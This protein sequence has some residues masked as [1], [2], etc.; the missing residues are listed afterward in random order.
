MK[1]PK[2]PST[3]IPE[4]VQGFG[5]PRSLAA[6]R[7]EAGVSAAGADI[8]PRPISINIPPPE[9]EP[10]PTARDFFN[11][12]KTVTIAAGPGTVIE[13]ASLT[14]QFGPGVVAVIKYVS[15]F[16]DAP[17]LATNVNWALLINGAPVP[18]WEALSFS[19]RV[20]ANFERTFP[21]TVRI[22]PNANVQVRITN[23]SA[24]AW[25]IG[26]SFGGWQWNAAEGERYTGL[27]Y[28]Y[29]K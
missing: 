3:R 13:P 28:L 29:V 22:P 15:L 21:G 2:K 19:P 18:G 16:A 12:L 5:R 27:P 8:A 17:T 11:I 20:A 24:S 14:R 26:A 10:I 4:D 9:V 25:D 6:A 7:A 1:P 23:L